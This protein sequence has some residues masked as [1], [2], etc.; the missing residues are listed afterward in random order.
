LHIKELI[1]LTFLVGE[2]ITGAGGEGGPR[3]IF[4]LILKHNKNSASCFNPSA[5][6]LYGNEARRQVLCIFEQCLEND[7]QCWTH[8]NFS[9][10]LTDLNENWH[11]I[12]H[13]KYQ[14]NLI[15]VLLS[16]NKTLYKFNCGPTFH[17]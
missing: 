15:V 8:V 3:G 11:G 7:I 10:P 13:E 5:P 6:S 2:C 14:T 16:V 1:Q 4:L 9:A 12:L 17:E